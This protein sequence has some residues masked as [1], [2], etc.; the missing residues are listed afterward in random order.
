VSVDV[1]R[2][3]DVIAGVAVIEGVLVTVRLAVA[4]V[5]T[6][7]SGDAFKPRKPNNASTSV[8]ATIAKRF[9]DDRTP[10]AGAL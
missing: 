3:V 10:S 4:V 8:S 2:R 9:I 5:V 1:S 6:C 7:S